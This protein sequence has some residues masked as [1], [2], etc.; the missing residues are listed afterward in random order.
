MTKKTLDVCAEIGRTIFFGIDHWELVIGHCGLGCLLREEERRND[1]AICTVLRRAGFRA[2]HS[3][4]VRSSPADTRLLSTQ[5]GR[6][7]RTPR[8]FSRRV[9]ASVERPRPKDVRK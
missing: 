4:R 7:R 2:R 9:S 6:V 8:A 1:L 3:S 5:L